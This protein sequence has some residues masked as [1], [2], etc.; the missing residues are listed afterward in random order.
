MGGGRRRGKSR[1]VVTGLSGQ[2]GQEDPIARLQTS[3]R[4]RESSSLGAEMR[5]GGE[6]LRGILVPGEGG[7]R[8][9]REWID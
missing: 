6:S 3:G 1:G 9:A 7:R 5:V 4:Q 2:A 8:L